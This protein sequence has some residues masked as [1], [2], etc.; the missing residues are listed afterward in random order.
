MEAYLRGRLFTYFFLF[1]KCAGK[2][3]WALIPM[4]KIYQTNLLNLVYYPCLSDSLTNAKT[5]I[6]N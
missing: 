5:V 2:C 6:Y 1:Q 4:N 3:S